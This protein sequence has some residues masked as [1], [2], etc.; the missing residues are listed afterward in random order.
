MTKKKINI[1]DATAWSNIDWD[2]PVVPEVLKKSDGKINIG[3]ANRLKANNPE[4]GKK[5]SK[6]LTGILTGPHD[7]KTKKAIATSLLGKEKTKEHKKA[8]S[9]AHKGHTPGNKGKAMTEK[10]K[11]I[12]SERRKGIATN[13]PGTILKKS[14]CPH[15]KFEGGGGMMKRWHFDNCKHK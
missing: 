5:I 6:A 11:K 9:D 10:Q 8:M 15:C 14:M 4:V 7:E 13:P 12:I 3:R 1:D 2:E